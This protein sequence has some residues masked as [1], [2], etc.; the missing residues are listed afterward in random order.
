MKIEGYDWECQSCSAVGW[1][2]TVKCPNCK[3]KI[4]YPDY[5]WENEPV[6]VYVPADDSE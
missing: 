5:K 2:A 3:E 6:I 4:N 1:G